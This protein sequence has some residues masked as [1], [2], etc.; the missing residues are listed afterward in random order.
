MEGIRI[1][2]LGT[3]LILKLYAAYFEVCGKSFQTQMGVHTRSWVEPFVG[4][5][6]QKIIYWKK[7]PLSSFSKTGP[8]HS[9]YQV[10]EIHMF[11]QRW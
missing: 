11:Q 10:L 5:M 1:H 7:Q 9:E 2:Q 3:F 8:G 6:L 4:Q